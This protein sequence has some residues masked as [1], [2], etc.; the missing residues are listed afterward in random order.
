MSLRPTTTARAPAI[1]IRERFKISM[2]PAGVQETSPG[3][4]VTKLPML[5][6]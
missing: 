2:I 5:I 4:C 1:G 6:G 3:R